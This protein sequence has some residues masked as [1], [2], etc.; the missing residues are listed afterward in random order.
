MLVE[1]V[2]ALVQAELQTHRILLQK[3]ARPTNRYR[4]SVIAFN[5]SRFFSTLLLT[6]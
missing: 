5:Y 2:I 1:E 3:E 4:L 6:P